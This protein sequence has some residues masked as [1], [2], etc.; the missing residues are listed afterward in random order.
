LRQLDC[1]G[2]DKLIEYL[3]IVTTC[4]KNVNELIN[5]ILEL[6]SLEAGKDNVKIESFSPGEVIQ[7]SIS[8]FNFKAKKKNIDLKF[9]Y[10]LLPKTVKA[11]KRQ[12]RQIIF[13]LIGNAVK[14]TNKGEVLVKANYRGGMLI[15]D[16]KDT[17]IGIPENMKEKIIEPFTQV[18]QSST[19][20][21]PGAGLGL[22]IVSKI[23]DSLGGILK[24]KSK[25]NEGT[26][27]SFIFP[28][29]ARREFKMKNKLA[30]RQKKDDA[31]SR[32]LVVE[33][34]EISILYLK[35]ILGGTGMDFKIAESFTRMSEICKQGFVP[36]IVLMD[37]SLPDAD[38]VECAKWL[39]KEFAGKEIKCI[40][41]TAHVM[42]D[43]I[44]DYKGNNFD[45]FI[46]KPYKKEELLDIINRNL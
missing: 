30:H 7:E 6:A 37:I 45:D 43:E 44:E 34:N 16:V 35:E 42:D 28:A 17:G 21:Y 39:H 3:S 12:F 22:T 26:T 19:R 25:L 27:A 15:I 14:F 18:D 20:K 32:I 23:L 9:E 11:A 1:P 38:G 24:I 13:N 40:A 33:D 31:P 46:A 36:D 41:Q 4:G 2:R 10:K 8:I 5:D 29:E